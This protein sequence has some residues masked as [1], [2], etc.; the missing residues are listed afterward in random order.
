L[1]LLKFTLGARRSPLCSAVDSGKSMAKKS[2]RTVSG[3]RALGAKRKVSFHQPAYIN[4]DLFT[5]L[6]MQ[7]SST[8]TRAR[9]RPGGRL[10]AARSC[11]A[12]PWEGAPSPLN[13]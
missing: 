2:G 4:S 13:R 12:P 8:A 6:T 9:F 1:F 5:S 11:S 10:E 7:L 3:I